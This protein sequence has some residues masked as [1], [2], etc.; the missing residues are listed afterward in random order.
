MK[1]SKREELLE[2]IIRETLWMARRY[3]DRRM[4][5]ATSMYNNAARIAQSLEILD[6]NPDGTWWAEDLDG[7][8]FSGLSEE[9]W[10]DLAKAKYGPFDYKEVL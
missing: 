3:A 10:E 8:S 5:Y 1:K 7:I 4:S 6:K 2:Y 9:E